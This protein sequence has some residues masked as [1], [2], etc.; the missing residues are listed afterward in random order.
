[1]GV[2]KGKTYALFLNTG[3]K[4]RMETKAEQQEKYWTSPHFKMIP[5]R[6]KNWLKEKRQINFQH[7]LYRNSKLTL[8]KKMRVKKTIR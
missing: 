5:S 2:R 3:I 1:M 8:Y 4:E 7:T 6:W